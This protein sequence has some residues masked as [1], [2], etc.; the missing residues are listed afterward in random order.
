MLHVNWLLIGSY[1]FSY[2]LTGYRFP[3]QKKLIINQSVRRDGGHRMSKTDCWCVGFMSAP[4]NIRCV[5]VYIINNSLIIEL[6][7]N[8]EAI[9]IILNCIII[10]LCSANPIFQTSVPGIS[11]LLD[12]IETKF[13]RLLPIFDDG[14]S[15]GTIGETVRCDRRWKKRWRPLNFQN[16]YLSFYTRYQRNSNGY[17]YVIGS[18]YQIRIVIMLYDQT[19]RNFRYDGKLFLVFPLDY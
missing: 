7:W 6:K 10:N 16:V 3:F 19:G 4:E 11:R 1:W 17:I 13:Q 9:Y 2:E 14:H 12:E 8:I 5:C 18:N 15:N